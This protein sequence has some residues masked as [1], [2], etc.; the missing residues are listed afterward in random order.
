VIFASTAKSRHTYCNI[1][2]YHKGLLY[3]VPVNE[4]VYFVGKGVS[5]I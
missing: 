3:S 2:G 4:R 5:G 1:T